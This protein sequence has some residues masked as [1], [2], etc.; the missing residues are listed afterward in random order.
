[1]FF[2]FK[3]VAW[4]G[5]WANGPHDATW[6]GKKNNKKHSKK[7]RTTGPFVAK[8]SCLFVCA[9]ACVHRRSRLCEHVFHWQCP[10]PISKTWIHDLLNSG[11]P[12]FQWFPEFKQSGFP[13]TMSYPCLDPCRSPCPKYR[14]WVNNFS[15][16]PMISWIHRFWFS[17]THD[18][19]P[20]IMD[21]DSG[22][23]REMGLT[24]SIHEIRNATGRV[25]GRGL[26]TCTPTWAPT[27][28]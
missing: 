1:M 4:E 2:A 7:C 15:W 23:G 10:Y 9:K 21:V 3:S 16:C 6:Q 28:S 25:M 26:C 8:K 19:C 5:A 24:W 17:W 22:M 13:V 20:D 12:V 14:S 27:R 11:F 18:P